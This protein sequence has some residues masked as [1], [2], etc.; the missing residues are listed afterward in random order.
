M[1]TVLARWEGA[2]GHGIRW[3]ADVADGHLMAE[4]SWLHVLDEGGNQV[5]DAVEVQRT[6]WLNGAMVRDPELARRLFDEVMR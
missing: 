4:Q 1:I 6:C 3:E 5:L 2:G